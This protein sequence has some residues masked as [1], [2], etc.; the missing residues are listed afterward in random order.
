MKLIDNYLPFLTNKEISPMG[1]LEFKNYILKSLLIHTSL[2]CFILVTFYLLKSRVENVYLL[3]GL[4][5][6]YFPTSFL[7]FQLNNFRARFKDIYPDRN[8]SFCF[9]T[10]LCF[11]PPLFVALTIYL[12]LRDS[13]Q[14]SAPPKIFCTYRYATLAVI[15]IIVIQIM[16]S[17]VSYWTARPAAYFFIEM[18]YDVKNFFEYKKLVSVEDPLIEKYKQKY[19]E[20]LKGIEL[21]LL[22]ALSL[23]TVHKEKSRKLAS[24]N[25]DFESNKMEMQFSYLNRLHDVLSVSGESGAGFLHFSPM[26]WLLPSGPLEIILLSI[27]ESEKM[28]DFGKKYTKQSLEAVKHIETKIERLPASEKVKARIR[29]ES[30]KQKFRDIKFFQHYNQRM[31]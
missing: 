29:L 25:S 22:T 26:H 15:P 11:L 2:V 20:S 6:F 14:E 8:I 5:L 3:I 12:C 1:K 18:C 4:A 19:G 17:R 28:N 31:L 27:I 23:R 21:E 10:F 24:D 7:C 30:I 16:S 13:S 9:F